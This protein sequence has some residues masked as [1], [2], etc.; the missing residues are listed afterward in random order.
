MKPSHRF[1]IWI[2]IAA[3]GLL[4]MSAACSRETRVDPGGPPPAQISNDPDV[5]EVNHPE[6]FPL[7][8]VETRQVA[9]R[10][11]V[12]GVVAP[13]V[14]LTVHVTSLSGG[15]VVDIHARLGDEVKKGQVLVVIRSQDLAMA[16][17]DYQ[18]F[19]ADELLARKA[20]DR[21]KLLYEH[22]AIAQKDVETAQDAEDKA[23]V[24]V[25]TAAER[26][27][28]LGGDINHL[29]PIIEVKSPISGAI[30]EQN[31]AGG[32]GVKSL[33]NTPNLFTIADL[34]RVWVLCDVYENNLA[35]VHPG[36]LVEVRLNAYQDRAFKGRI[37]N[38]SQLLDPSARTA[39]VRV[40]LAN[41]GGIFRP[42]MFA[43]ARFTSR[44]SIKRMALPATA[45]LRLH[46]K[47][48]VFR[49]EG[50]RRYRRVE[51]QAGVQLADGYH[52]ILSGIQS[53]DKLVANALQFSAA[54]E[55]K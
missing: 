8:A 13:D 11:N 14:S 27:R 41:S 48:W 46:D 19:I 29:S 43:V 3:C 50:D 9:D 22:G 45:L 15:R 49:H 4:P 42:G 7:I 18:K 25:E 20:L 47:D 33:D 16:I 28:I 51:I 37:S 24:D 34:S 35:Q 52:T 12:N 36:D 1:R 44:G 21:A 17:S 26:I 54:M 6:Q 38:I 53:G 23:R 2:A 40:E 32:E 30:V 10:L 39:K 55:Q 31:T 5:F